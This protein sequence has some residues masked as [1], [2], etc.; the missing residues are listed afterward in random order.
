M[1]AH[2]QGR[3]FPQP[4]LRFEKIAVAATIGMAICLYGLVSLDSLTK[5]RKPATPTARLSAASP[6]PNVAPSAP[7]LIR[8]SMVN[9]VSASHAVESTS[10]M[11]AL[12]ERIG[13]RMDRV[14]ARGEVPRL[15]M[16]SLPQDM[17]EI[18]PAERRKLLFIK[19]AL[20][21]ILQVNEVILH[22]R[23][24][25]EALRD[26][27]R[28]D[29]IVSADDKA[30]LAELIDRYGLDRPDFE[31]L[32]RRV[33]IVPPS[34]ALAQSAAESGWGTSR[35]AREGNALF[36]QRTWR[37][38]PGLVPRER[39]D[40]EKYKVRVFGHLI[41]GVKSYVHNLNSHPAYGEF[42]RLRETLRAEGKRLAGDRLA[43]ALHSYS[44]SGAEY[45]KTIRTI[46]R[47]NRLVMFDA[48]RLGDHVSLPPLG[49]DA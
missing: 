43:G 10:K 20:P 13:Y 26:R 4:D 22:D 5:P 9:P 18:R 35:F 30:W 21:L 47:V 48:L 14:L 17:P 19:A 38:K 29:L 12:F 25:I 6:V 16:S 31:A 45:I 1:T 36:G 42:R 44:E 3:V 7:A 40:G 23:A 46:M 24:R 27:H 11:S 8:V 2:G 33:D 34:L 15:F 41:D 28:R 49:P 37:G 39:P 32:L